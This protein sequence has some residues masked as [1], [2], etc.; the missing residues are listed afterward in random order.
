[1]CVYVYLDIFKMYEEEVYKMGFMYVVVG[2]MVCL[3]YYVDL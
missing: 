3:S 1:M 2:V